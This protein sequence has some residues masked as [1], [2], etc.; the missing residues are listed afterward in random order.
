MRKLAA[1]MIIIF[2]IISIVAT[3]AFFSEDVRAALYN[4]VVGTVLMPIH[5]GI[6]SLAN[7]VAANGFTYIAVTSL[8]LIATGIFLGYMW[9]HWLSQ[10]MPTWLG[11]AKTQTQPIVYQTIPAGNSPQQI[12]IPQSQP[13]QTVTVVKQEEPKA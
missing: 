4:S 11:G 12:Q 5:D 2:V 9:N 13:V 7:T 3:A 8:A 10:K 1:L 6:V